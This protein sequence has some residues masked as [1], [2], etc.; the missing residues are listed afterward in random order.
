MLK[1]EDHLM[2]L[3]SA[4]ENRH[5]ESSE[6]TLNECCCGSGNVTEVLP[7]DLA[8]CANEFFVLEFLDGLSFLVYVR[9]YVK[10]DED[11]V[12]FVSHRLD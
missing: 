2:L 5:I 3:S 11:E 1:L 9:N 10:M 8:F 6:L 4:S 7:W 12:A